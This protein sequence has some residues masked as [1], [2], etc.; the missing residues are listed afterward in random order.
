MMGVIPLLARSDDAIEQ[1]ETRWSQM[2]RPRQ[3]GHVNLAASR[4]ILTQQQHRS[5][6][7][8]GFV[9]LSFLWS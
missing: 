4:R 6:L 3:I 9:P 2:A 7:L 8:D 5:H 1:P